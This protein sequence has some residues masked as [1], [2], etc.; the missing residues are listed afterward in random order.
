M[1]FP[2]LPPNEDQAGFQ[3]CLRTFN[4]LDHLDLQIFADICKHV[5]QVIHV[6][7]IIHVILV[8]LSFLQKRCGVY[9]V[10]PTQITGQ[11]HGVFCALFSKFLN[12]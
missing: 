4:C 12:P 11:L 3:Q 1:P 6:I 7:H 9:I 10:L 8:K 2:G 5:I